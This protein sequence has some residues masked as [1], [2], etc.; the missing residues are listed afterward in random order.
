[1]GSL[2]PLCDYRNLA[3]DLQT[4][5]ASL[6]LEQKRLQRLSWNVG[7]FVSQ[8]G[9]QAVIAKLDD[10]LARGRAIQFCDESPDNQFPEIAWQIFGLMGSNE[11]VVVA[12]CGE[13]RLAASRESGLLYPPM[14]DRIFGIDV[15]DQELA[16]QLSDELWAR[17][18]ERLTSEVNRLRARDP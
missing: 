14:A 18:S 3:T 4:M 13:L 6:V 15:A 11:V 17:E 12:R 2:H 8:D 16:M 9:S 1:M 7:A 10:A 5:A